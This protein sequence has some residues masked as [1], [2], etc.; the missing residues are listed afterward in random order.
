LISGASKT[1]AVAGVPIPAAEVELQR[2]AADD[3]SDLLEWAAGKAPRRICVLGPSNLPHH[4]NGKIPR[5]AL[6]ERFLCEIG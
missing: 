5:R 6:G 2:G 4:S 3:E 1:A